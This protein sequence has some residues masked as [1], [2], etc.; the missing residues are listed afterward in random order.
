MKWIVRDPPPVLDL[1]ESLVG[2]PGKKLLH[3]FDSLQELARASPEEL[4]SY[5]TP[6]RVRKLTAAIKLHHAI[7]SENIENS[8][9]LS[10]ALDVFQTYRDRFKG[11]PQEH[12]IALLLNSKNRVI[13]EVLVSKG[14]LNASVVHP[15]E[16]F[17]PA[18]KER[19]CSIL[20]I[21]NHPSG[22]PSPSR[23]DIDITKRLK[24][25]GELIGIQMLDH[26]IIGG[27]DFFSF[28]E[29]RLL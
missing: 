4:K 24:E 8:P 21:H 27:S 25:T 23:E 12:F 28:K 2:E 3:E 7:S 1:L 19:A 22:D 26:V 29:R 6:A 11:E 10:S 16:V 5:L 18:I 14:S 17:A 9:R 15:R 13:K 20:V